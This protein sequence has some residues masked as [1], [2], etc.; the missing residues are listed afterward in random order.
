MHFYDIVFSIQMVMELSWQPRVF[1]VYMYFSDISD[2][3]RDSPGF[4][5]TRTEVEYQF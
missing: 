2:I 1:I 5:Y 3:S 4:L